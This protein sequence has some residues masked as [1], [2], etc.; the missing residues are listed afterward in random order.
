MTK[1]NT[2]INTKGEEVPYNSPMVN[3]IAGLEDISKLPLSFASIIQD[4]VVALVVSTYLDV[5]KE[6]RSPYTKSESAALCELLG[7]SPVMVHQLSA[8][9]IPNYKKVIKLEAERRSKVLVNDT[10]NLYSAE[11]KTLK[12]ENA[13][14]KVREARS[15]KLIDELRLEKE[16]FKN[17]LEDEIGKKHEFIVTT[18]NE[19]AADL[20]TEKKELQK[21]NKELQDK[22]DDL[23]IQLSSYS[24]I[25][26][27]AINLF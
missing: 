22:I 11:I 24:R 3:S 15:L 14:F 1:S 7:I 16:E 8:I 27:W 26:K 20:I 5:D 9:K 19:H 10:R 4:H 25:P 6:D 18:Q 23:Y 2:Y 17:K 21:Q 12:E 13:A